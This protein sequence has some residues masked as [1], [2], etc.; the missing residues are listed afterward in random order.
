MLV[1]SILLIPIQARAGQDIIYKDNDV[2]LEGYWAPKTCAAAGPSPLVLI[3][4]QWNGITDHEKKHADLLAAECYNAFVIDMYGKGIRP[5]D[6]ENA[7]K[8][9]T[10]YKSDSALA[11][12]RIKAGMDFALTL[13]GI[14]PSKIA[15]MGYCFGG[16]MA[17]ELARSG[18]DIDAA[19]SFHGALSTPAP[20]TAPGQI[21][22]SIL[23]LHGAEDPLVPPAEVEAF[24][25]EMR[26][27][28]AD[29]IFTEYAHAV[30]AFT[31]KAAG[32]DPSKGF[33]YNDM[34]YKRSWQATLDFLK[35]KL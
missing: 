21:K 12:R 15:I 9:A 14:D 5:A 4:H 20:A 32:D 31:Q 19:I 7:G 17:L 10:K 8:Q 2:T 11:R 34:A 3:V 13:G 18:V 23:V 26:T 28:N 35:E 33:A 1:L 29:W 25:S 24:K 16:S 6:N 27:A 30:H 22:S